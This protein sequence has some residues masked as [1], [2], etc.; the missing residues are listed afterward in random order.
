MTDLHKRRFTRVRGKW[1]VEMGVRHSNHRWEGQI[2]QVSEGG[3]FVEVG[4][5]HALGTHVMLR[6]GF[7]LIVDVICIGVVRNQ[8][9]GVG[10]GVEFLTLSDTDREHI[11]GLVQHGGKGS[12]DG[13][14]PVA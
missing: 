10:V 3:G 11:G 9:P 6:F 5:D 4:G 14:A 7:P 13:Q 12:G 1:P 8:K 2:T